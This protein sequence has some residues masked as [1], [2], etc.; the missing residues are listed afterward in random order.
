MNFVSKVAI[1]VTCLAL[2]TLFSLMAEEPSST[3]GN[4]RAWITDSPAEIVEGLNTE[5]KKHPKRHETYEQ[6][7]ISKIEMF[8]EDY[9]G[10]RFVFDK[11]EIWPEFE[12]PGTMGIHP[13]EDYFAFTIKPISSGK[14]MSS[15]KFPF[16]AKKAFVKQWADKIRDGD[17]RWPWCVISGTVQK[18][19]WRWAFDKANETKWTYAFVV[20]E[21]VVCN[22]KTGEPIS[23]LFFC[24]EPVSDKQSPETKSFTVINARLESGLKAGKAQE[25]YEQGKKYY[26]GDGVIQDAGRAFRLFKEASE[27]GSAEADARLAF[28]YWVG[29]GSAKDMV[30]SYQYA[31]KAEASIEEEKFEL[32]LSRYLLGCFYLD[33][34]KL[35]SGELFLKRDAEKAYEYFSKYNYTGGRAI[36]AGFL[37][38]EMEYHGDGT[39][40]DVGAA[41]ESFYSV[42]KNMPEESETAGRAAM[43]LG[44]M[45]FTGEGVE[46][47]EKEAFKWLRYGARTAY[48]DLVKEA[49][50][51]LTYNEVAEF[52]R[53]GGGIVV[54]PF[55]YKMANLYEGRGDG[56]KLLEKA[57]MTYFT[58]QIWTIKYG[59]E[60]M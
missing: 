21:F 14:K 4:A 32:E 15:N 39:K 1:C 7:N 53:L 47:N 60:D 38:A 28:M 48:P 37:K 55:S 40:K 23:S 22:T 27:L 18:F 46:R 56:F 42:C 34:I 51:P 20:D 19:G 45:Y 9:V 43:C 12:E 10:R 58:P 57:L 50:K 2:S 6:A 3:N 16:I 52:K 30:K 26:D 41:A 24:E 36:L 13:R 54:T 17:F 44:Q 59:P 31:R 33:G 35:S 8:P 29:E 49:K 11:C 25:L 5:V